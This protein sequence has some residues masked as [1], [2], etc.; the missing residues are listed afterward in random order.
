MD[1]SK[2]TPPERTTALRKR[3]LPYKLLSLLLYGRHSWLQVELDGSLTLGLGPLARLLR[4]D[5]KRIK[6]Y[7]LWLETRNYLCEVSF[8]HGQAKVS[9]RPPPNYQQAEQ[10]RVAI[11]EHRAQAFEEVRSL[12]ERTN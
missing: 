12:V 6:E 4:T 1:A 8:T 7:L 2:N 9:L 11:N 3:F 5:P 10:N